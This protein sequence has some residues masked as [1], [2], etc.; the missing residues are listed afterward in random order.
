MLPPGWHIRGRNRTYITP[1]SFGKQ[2]KC[3]NINI[4]EITLLELD[5]VALLL[6][7]TTPVYSLTL[8]T[9]CSFNP[10]CDKTS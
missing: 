10:S 9:M 2:K 3:S 8:H 5:L 4:S 1:A 7:D 6:I